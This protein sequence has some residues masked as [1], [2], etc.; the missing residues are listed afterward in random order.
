MGQVLR[1]NHTF[2]GFKDPSGS[3]G[4]TS[5]LLI[6]NG[7]LSELIG[8]LQLLM[9]GLENYENQAKGEGEMDDAIAAQV[10]NWPRPITVL[11]GGSGQSNSSSL[12]VSVA[13]LGVAGY[14]YIWWKG[15]SFSDIMFVTKHNMEKA[16]ADLT[17]KLQHA[18]DVID[19]TRSKAACGLTNKPKEIVDIDAGDANN[20][21]AAVEYLEDIYKDCHLAKQAFDEEISECD[22]LNEES[23]KDK[24][25]REANSTAKLGGGDDVEVINS[26]NMTATIYFPSM[27]S[28][29]SFHYF[30]NGS[31]CEANGWLVRTS[32]GFDTCVWT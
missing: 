2:W 28:I 22:T 30:C 23:F 24:E 20:E 10:K 29:Y 17:T 32:L 5:T 19:V 25:S 27:T 12:V 21:L 18:S 1:N 6:K 3:H 11:N 26:S 14:G 7:K 15:L 8:E 4:Y 16:V 13:V 31:D 9:K